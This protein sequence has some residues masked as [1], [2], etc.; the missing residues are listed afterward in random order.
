MGNLKMH[1]T[2]IG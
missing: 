2:Y 1:P